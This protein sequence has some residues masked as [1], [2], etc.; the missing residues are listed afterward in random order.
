MY[1]PVLAGLALLGVILVCSWYISATIIIDTL[2]PTRR[3]SAASKRARVVKAT[4]KLSHEE[5]V[6]Q[7]G[8]PIMLH[9][10]L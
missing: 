8:E 10:V 1:N 3:S 9:F 7:N 5:L 2:W 6:K 4:T